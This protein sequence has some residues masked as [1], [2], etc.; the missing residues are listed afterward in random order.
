MH[1]L[2]D[3]YAQLPVSHNLCQ[4]EPRYLQWIICIEADLKK[5]R[6]LEISCHYRLFSLFNLLYHLC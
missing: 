4:D 5:I 1:L 3:E 6:F 2:L